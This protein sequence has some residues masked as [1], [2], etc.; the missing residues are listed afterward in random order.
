MGHILIL[1]SSD[2]TMPLLEE[3][4]RSVGGFAEAG[5]LSWNWLKPEKAA[6]IVLDSLPEKW[7]QASLEKLLEEDRIDSFLIPDDGHRKKKLLI[8]DMDSTMVIGETLDDLAAVCGL[9][10]EIAVIT[11]KAMC[12]ELDFREALRTRVRMLKG[13]SDSALVK[14]VAG[15]ELMPGG[16]SLVRVMREN[17][18]YCVLVSGGFTSF[19]EPVAKK[20][21]FHVHHGNVLELKDNKLTGR[22]VDPILDHHAKLSFLQKYAKDHQLS[23]IECLAVGDGANDLSMINAAGL[24]VGYHPKAYLKERADSSILYGDLTALL[25]VQGYRN[26]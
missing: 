24:G 9:K 20:L 22:V 7:S 10:K 15:I 13:L 16:Q 3:H 23:E 12:G 18:A 21:G 6:E 8:S 2:S 5:N 25:Y 19:T 1:V 4:L 26:F 11:E 14:T 17:G